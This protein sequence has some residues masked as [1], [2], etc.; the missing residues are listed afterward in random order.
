MGRW[1][2]KL[3]SDDVEQEVQ[4]PILV[5]EEMSVLRQNVIND[6]TIKKHKFEVI[7]TLTVRLKLD[8]GLDEDHE[9]GGRSEDTVADTQQKLSLSQGRR[10]ALEA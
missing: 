5:G 6:Q 3:T 10:H 7:G 2:S 1:V 9:V 4:L 8:S